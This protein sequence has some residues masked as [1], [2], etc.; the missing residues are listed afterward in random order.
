MTVDFVWEELLP[1]LDFTTALDDWLCFYKCSTFEVS[2][3]FFS[4]FFD[5]VI[6]CIPFTFSAWAFGPFSCITF[7]RVAGAGTHGRCY[8]C[9]VSGAVTTGIGLRLHDEQLLG[10]IE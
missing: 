4:Q 3:I 7:S 9:L 5:I 6:S 2:E 8:G 10:F 1:L